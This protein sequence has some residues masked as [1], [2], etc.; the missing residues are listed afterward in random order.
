MWPFLRDIYDHVS[1]NLDLVE[2]QRDLV[3]GSLDIYLSSVANRTNQ[4][5]KVLTVLGT[6]ALPALVISGMY[7]MNLKGLPWTDSPHG[8]AIVGGVMAATTAIL[9]AVLRLMRWF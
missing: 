6:I 8:A 5:M 2:M 9:L 1:R 3:T 7:G 4:V